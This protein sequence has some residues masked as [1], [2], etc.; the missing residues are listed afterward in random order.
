[1]TT[2][3]RPMDM[4][5]ADL[6]SR[7]DVVET[8]EAELREAKQLL[9]ESEDELMTMMRDQGVN[10]VSSQGL[11]LSITESIVPQIKDW[12][13][14]ERYVL[15]NGATHLLERRVHTTAWREELLNRQDTPIPGI[16]PYTRVR[17][18]VRA[19]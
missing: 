5:V 8:I 3:V 14:F 15:R 18:S 1:M 11:T 13:A 12:P 7:R 10:R 4:V 9:A 2:A 16:E 17:L 6:R 19:E